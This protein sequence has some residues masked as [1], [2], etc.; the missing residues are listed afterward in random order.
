MSVIGQIKIDG[1]FQEDEADILGAFIGNECVGVASPVYVNDRNAYYV[2]VS[3]FGNAVHVNKPVTFK[4]WD[5]GTGEVYPSVTPS[6][7]INFSNGGIAGSS[8]IPVLFDAAILVE[9]TINLNNGWT[10][11]STNVTNTNP[12]ILN[13]VKTSLAGGIGLM[14]KGS[15]SFMQPPLWMGLSSISEKNMYMVSTSKAHTMTLTGRH[16]NPANTPITLNP[17]W[18]WIGYVPSFSLSVKDA[19]AGVNPQQDDQIKG[20]NRFAS[21]FGNGLWVGSLTSMQPGSGYMYYSKNSAPQ[22]FT[23][24]SVALRSLELRIAANEQEPKWPADYTRFP[25]SMTITAIVLDNDVPLESDRV[26][27]AAFSGDECRGSVMLQYVEG[28]AQPYLG[29]LMVH[30]EDGE[31]ITYRVFDHATQT[32]YAATGPADRFHSDGIYGNPLEPAVVK[33]SGVTGNDWIENGLSIYPNPVKDRLFIRRD[34]RQLERVEVV[35]LGGRLI[36]LEEDFTGEALDVSR[37]EKGVYVLK[38]VKNG[39]LTVHKIIKQ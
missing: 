35:D 28:L 3:I 32:E 22:S 15:S 38:I 11:I 1:Y 39:Q 2:F 18:S 5:A 10:W 17:G 33:T 25:S 31:K 37:L 6:V 29:F 7:A 4:L 14:F 36:L 13:Q 9:Q 16:A 34:V 27:V 19:L 30:G 26:E 21:Y 8:E 12:T 24:P 20:Q 23:Y